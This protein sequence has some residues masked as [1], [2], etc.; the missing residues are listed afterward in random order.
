MG[1]GLGYVSKELAGELS[2]RRT[3]RNST[4]RSLDLT[5]PFLGSQTKLGPVG[6]MA[7]PQPHKPMPSSSR[8]PNGSVDLIID[9]ENLAD[10]TP[11][12]LTAKELE[13]QEGTIT[14]T[15]SRLRPHSPTPPAF[16]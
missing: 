5:R 10:M 11:V 6:R 14:P 8:L 3:S 13:S 15:S 16:G 2:S 9:N 12:H 1:A 7:Q 4:T